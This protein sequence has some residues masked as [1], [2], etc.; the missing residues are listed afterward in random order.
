MNFWGG[1]MPEP[2]TLS[3]VFLGEHGWSRCSQYYEHPYFSEE[4]WAQPRENCPVKIRSISSHY[5]GSSGDFDCSITD[6]FTIRLPNKEIINGLS[7]RWS[8]IGG[9]FIDESDNRIIT[10]PTVHI[11]GP[12]AL[13]VKQEELFE[14]LNRKGLAIIWMILGEK[15]VISA[16]QRPENNF[17]TQISGVYYQTDDDLKGFVNYF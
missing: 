7:L 6:S 15:A 16:G 4:G 3:E 2:P 5:L 12:S 10:D 9:D 17:S 13:L 11:D 8:G 1:W 14:F